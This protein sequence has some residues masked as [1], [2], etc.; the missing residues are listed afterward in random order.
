MAENIKAE[1][2]GRKI[3]RKIVKG[4]FYKADDSTLKVAAAK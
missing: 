1:V 3:V 4:G 2:R